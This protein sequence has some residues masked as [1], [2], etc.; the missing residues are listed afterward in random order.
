MN[1]T[2][3]GDATGFV[4]D[5]ADDTQES[6]ALRGLEC[7]C[8]CRNRQ[9]VERWVRPVAD[10]ARFRFYAGPFIDLSREAG[11]FDLPLLVINPDILDALLL[12]DVLCYLVDVVSGIEHHR[13]MGAQLD[14]VA[15]PVA[16]FNDVL[17]SIC[18][19]IVYVEVCPGENA[20][21]KNQPYQ[22]NK[23]GDKTAIYSDRVL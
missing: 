22:S 4:I 16:R 1:V 5:R 8:P 2:T 7:S 23:L 20:N 19:L 17:E 12:A 21:K 3:S 13:V 6:V 11:E 10:V 18:L 15:E 14:G 9:F